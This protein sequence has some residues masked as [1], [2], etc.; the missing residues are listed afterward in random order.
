MGVGEHNLINGKGKLVSEV[1]V[2]YNTL[3]TATKDVSF[4]LLNN[5][6]N[7]RGFISSITEHPVPLLHILSPYCTS[8]PPTAHPFPL[9]LIV[10]EGS[11]KGLCYARLTMVCQDIMLSEII[12]ILNRLYLVGF[13]RRRISQALHR[14][15]TASQPCPGKFRS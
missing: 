7:F 9:L 4:P 3:S 8:C 5:H 2:C 11:V 13:M 12:S 6:Y 14:F 10:E 1:I 15:V